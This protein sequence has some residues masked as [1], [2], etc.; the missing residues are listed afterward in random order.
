MLKLFSQIK[1][2]FT[3]DNLTKLFIII[4]IIAVIYSMNNNSQ[5]EYFQN[6][7]SVSYSSSN[8]DNIFNTEYIKLYNNVIM[9]TEKDTKNIDYIFQ[10]T[11]IS[12][13]GLVVNIGCKTGWINNYLKENYGVNSIGLD[14]SS[15]MIDTCRNKYSN[16]DFNVFNIDTLDTININHNQPITHI[17]C[18]NME[19][20]YIDNIDY[21][22]AQCYKGLEING[23]LIL[24][25]VDH[26]KF[27]N[28]SVYSRLNH[29]NPNDLSIKKV[30]DSV[31]KFN[32]IVYNTRYRV[33][34]ND[35][36]NDTVWF[37]ETIEN[38]NNNTIYENI[39][40]FNPISNKEIENIA[41]MN[42]F[43]LVNVV[44]IQLDLGLEHY[45]NEYLYIFKK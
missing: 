14:R 25:L 34:P 39:H 16:I 26:N 5:R 22:F 10:K 21:F 33:F 7:N 30:N 18:L 32:D 20:Y 3:E 37:T 23:Y 9:D 4:T 35:F 12:N 8:D 1:K 40:N 38:I 28:T 24:N 42:N 29:F 31:I 44:N 2:S 15:Y 19:I 41:N 27:N 43:K 6:T 11:N 36:G 13:Q 17:I 45:N